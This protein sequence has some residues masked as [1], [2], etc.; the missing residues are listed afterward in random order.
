M[1]T[2]LPKRQIVTYHF[3]SM[4]GERVCESDQQGRIAIRSS[5]VSEK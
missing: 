5:A 1:R 2:V 4:F 3:N